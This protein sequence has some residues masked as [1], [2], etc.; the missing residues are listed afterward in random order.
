MTGSERHSHESIEEQD[1]SSTWSQ[2]N[3]R[4]INDLF[5][6]TGLGGR[7]VFTQGVREP[8]PAGHGSDPHAGGGV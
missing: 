7:Q 5:R 2:L 6:I 4:Y 3:S 1:Q 8:G